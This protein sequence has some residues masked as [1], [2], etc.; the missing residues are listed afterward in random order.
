MNHIVPS[1]INSP[2]LEQIMGQVLATNIIT[3]IEDEL[4][5]DGTGHIKSIYITAECKE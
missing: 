3:F 2:G 4:I 1:N 5:E